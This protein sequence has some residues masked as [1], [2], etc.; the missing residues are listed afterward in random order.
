MT[1]WKTRSF[2]SSLAISN[3]LITENR[4]YIVREGSLMIYVEH[5]DTR[6][7]SLATIYFI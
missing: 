6:F 5:M 2:P 1:V 4:I 7:F 3:E